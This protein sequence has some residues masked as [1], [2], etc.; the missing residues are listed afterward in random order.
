MVWEMFD[1]GNMLVGKCLVG[2]IVFSVKYRSGICQS[3]SCPVGEL[4]VY[5]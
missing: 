5:R 1:R 2:E 3:G 4:K